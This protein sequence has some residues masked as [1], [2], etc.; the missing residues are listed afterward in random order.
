MTDYTEMIKRLRACAEGDCRH[1]LRI[2][3]EACVA[4]L[5][6]EA[7]DA[8]EKLAKPV[9]ARWVQ[10]LAKED[11]DTLLAYYFCDKC[12]TPQYYATRFCGY[13]GAHMTG[14]IEQEVAPSD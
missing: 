1:Y 11:P 10:R 14:V 6:R 9:E 5:L 8:I 2:A 12:G 3:G 7:A 4:P 13:C